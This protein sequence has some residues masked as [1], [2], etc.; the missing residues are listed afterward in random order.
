[1][2]DLTADDHRI[3]PFQKLIEPPATC[4]EEAL[5][6]MHADQQSAELLQWLGVEGID[7]DRH[8]PGG[9]AGHPRRLRK[10]ALGTAAGEKKR[11]HETCVFLAFTL[12]AQGEEAFRRGLE[13]F[14]RDLP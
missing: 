10:R 4:R 12:L 11:L 9:D 2:R 7:V 1:M 6:D 8:D 13:C 5:I 14:R 3:A